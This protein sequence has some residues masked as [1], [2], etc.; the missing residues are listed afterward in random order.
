MVGRVTT[1]APWF[2]STVNILMSL[3]QKILL[4]RVFS[5]FDYLKQKILTKW[6][7]SLSFYFYYSS[8]E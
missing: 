3:L 4:G 2:P 1:C 6:N 5:K 8:L 7:I